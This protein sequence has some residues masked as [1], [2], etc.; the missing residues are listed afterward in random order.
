MGKQGLLRLER[1]KWSGDLDIQIKYNATTTIEIVNPI[2]HYGLVTLEFDSALKSA[3]FSG[4][5]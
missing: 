3:G 4:K 5:I 1:R 2:A